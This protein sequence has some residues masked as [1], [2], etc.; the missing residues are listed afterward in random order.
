MSILVNIETLLSNAVVEGTRMEYKK[1]WNSVPVMRTVCAFANDFE[2]EGSGYIIIGVEEKFGKPIRPVEGFNPIKL[3]QIEKELIG[4]CNLIQPS[5]FPR[6]SLEEVDQ[7]HVLVIW[8]PAGANRPYQVPDDVLSKHKKYNF[9]IRFRSS[10]IVPND[11]QATELIQLTAKVPFDDRVNTFASITDLSRSLMREHLQETHSKLYEESEEMS[12]EELAEKMNLSQGINEHLFPKNIGLLMFSKKTQDYFK[13]AIIELV[14]FPHG[15]AGTF[16]EKL[17]SGV[18]QKQLTDVLAYMKANIIKTKVIKYSD[19]EKSDRIENYPIDAV[20][21]A[22]ANAVFHRNYEFQDPIEIRILPDAIEIISYNGVDPSL[23]QADFDK[24]RV[25][26]RRYR[27]RR[28][29]EFLKELRLTEGRG[30]GIPTIIKSLSEN[31]S[32]E[33]IFDTNEPERLHF[34]VEIPIHPQFSNRVNDYVNDQVNDYV[35]D[36]VI[37]ILRFCSTPKSKSE[38]LAFLGLKNHST[39]FKKHVFNLLHL[40]LIEFTNKEIPKDRNQ[41]YITTNKGKLILGD[42]VNDYVNDHVN[43]HIN[44]Q[45]ILILRFCST[46]KSRSEILAFLG[47]KNHSMNFKKHVFHLLKYKLIEFTLNDNPK[48]RNQKYTISNKG[49]LLLGDQV[50]NPKK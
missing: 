28:I 33:P 46:P 6:L 23:K 27:N 4:F 42:H 50:S 40:N 29:G 15:L 18:I 3:E 44:D 35:N 32:T 7:K 37:L 47:L 9:R 22:L 1:S 14:E 11:E 16:T 30:T 49:M 24:G 12:L 48:N 10:S 21:E 43:D 36:Q 41:K 13:G 31:G 17:F 38:I 8:C 20:E 34:I 5:Y 45:T 39:N 25:R 19:R 2:N 26:A